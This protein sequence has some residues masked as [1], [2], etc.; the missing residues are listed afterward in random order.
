M[1]C[2]FCKEPSDNSRSIEHVLPES[3][4][5]TTMILPAGVVCDSCNNYFARKVEAPFLNSEE[6][7]AFRSHQGIPNKRGRVPPLSGILDSEIPVTLYRYPG[8]SLSGLLDMP[9]GSAERLLKI[10]R[11][12]IDFPHLADNLDRRA[13]SRFLAKMAVESLAARLLR[14]PEGLAYLVDETS[15]GPIR[16]YARYGKGETWPYSIRRIYDQDKKWETSEGPVQR[17]WESDFLVVD[18]GQ[19]YF[20]IAI[21][22]LEL[23]TNIS[24]PALN[25]YRAWLKKNRGISPLYVGE[26]IGE[27]SN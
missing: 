26:K 8:R 1:R 4:G 6:I 12:T 7:V 14:S 21:F 22:G 3:L 10:G 17:V 27:Q 19:W 11:G 5:N 16:N 20:V 18:P 24:F 13:V 25:G 15:L 2:L 23:T 9:L